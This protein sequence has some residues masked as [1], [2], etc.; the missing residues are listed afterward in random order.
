M[1]I[2][3]SKISIHSN[4][5]QIWHLSI[6]SN[7]IKELRKEV[8][9]IKTDTKSTREKRRKMISI[10][11]DEIR[12]ILF[13]DGITFDV[14]IATLKSLIAELSRDGEVFLSQ[15]EAAKIPPYKD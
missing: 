1:L 12:K 6:C 13:T 3:F 14:A 2:T 4:L 7:M 10:K 15:T 8:G 11:K 9:K 5:F